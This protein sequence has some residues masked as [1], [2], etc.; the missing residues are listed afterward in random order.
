MFSGSIVALITPM[1]NSGKIDFFSLKKLLI[2]HMHS[3]TSAILILST[4]GEGYSLNFRE[5]CKMLTYVLDFCA[6]KIPIIMGIGS[7]SLQAI[8]KQIS[9]Y[10]QTSISGYLISTPY[11]SCPNQVGLYQYFKKISEFTN[12]P[13]IIYN[14]PRRT[15]C[16]ILPETIAKLSKITNIVGVKES[17]GDL[18]RIKK[19]KFLSN[20]H[21]SILCGDDINIVDFMKL[22]GCGVISMAANILAKESDQL[23]FL[24]YNKHYYQAEKIYRKFYQLYSALTIAPNPAPIKWACKFLGLIKTYKSRLPIINID[25]KNMYFLKKILNNTNISYQEI[26]NF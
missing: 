23:C 9:F 4:T 25:K 19:I 24:M 2:Y 18:S 12:I 13:Q 3:K 1:L 11:Y 16:D 26:N 20:N 21:F 8:L 10:N 14:I 6:K 22:G 5:K 17:S 7:S 15:G